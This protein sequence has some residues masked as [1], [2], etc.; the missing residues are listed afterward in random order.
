MK[1]LFTITLLTCCVATYVAA[2]QPTPIWEQTGFEQPESALVDP[3]TGL[4]YISNIAGQPMEKNAQGYISQLNADGTV[5]E[6][7]WASDMNAPKGMAIVDNHL[8]V[9]DIDRLRVF[10]LDTG[11]QTQELMADAGMLNDIAA[12]SAGN[13]YISDML[14]T[15]LFRYHDGELE[16]WL[17][18][19]ELQHPNGVFVDGEDL[20]VATWGHPIADDFTT[21]TPGSL[22]RISLA[23]KNLQPITG[24]EQLGNLDGVVKIG[25][26]FWVNDWING[27][28]YRVADGRAEKI[29]QY[30]AGLADINIGG[31]L[32]FLPLMLDGEV[33]AVD[34]TSLP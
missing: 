33:R 3:M 1:A 24:G 34:I 29:A 16:L 20:I 9:A 22:M 18:S 10:N 32:L 26:A 17:N 5:R 7:H 31:G 21:Q 28:L 6:K 11:I 23:D 13:A 27:A 2:S 4:V 8:L 12:D 25:D 30:P 15:Q 19:E 14:G